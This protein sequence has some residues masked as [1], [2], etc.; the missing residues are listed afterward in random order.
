ML[1]VHVQAEDDVFLAAAGIQVLAEGI[2]DVGAQVDVH[3]VRGG[4]VRDGQGCAPVTAH[5]PYVTTRTVTAPAT[6]PLLRWNCQ[7][8]GVGTTTMEGY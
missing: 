2:G 7:Q 1:Y 4:I 6:L 3:G 8:P 5:R